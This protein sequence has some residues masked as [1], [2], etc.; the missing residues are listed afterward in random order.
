[1]KIIIDE[2]L[3][4]ESTEIVIKCKSKDDK[5]YSLLKKIE[6]LNEK[7]VVNRNNESY[8]IEPN[9]LLYIETVDKKTFL[10]D[11]ECVYETPMKLYE[12][13]SL[14]EIYDFIRVNK[15]SIINL[16]QVQS[17]AP[18]FNGRIIMKMN[19]EEKIIVSR[20]YAINVKQKLG[21]K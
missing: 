8:F 1:M 12:L 9:N 16:N 6:V 13:E 21:V 14:L 5:I 10:Y 17:L 15:S 18:D 2:N 19:N 4:Y 20:Q 3:S 11:Q 7:I